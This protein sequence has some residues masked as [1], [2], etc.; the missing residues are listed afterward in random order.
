MEYIIY[1]DDGFVKSTLLEK[2]LN[3]QNLELLQEWLGGSRRLDLL[4]CRWTS[5]YSSYSVASFKS[6]DQSSEA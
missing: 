4:C 1:S 2:V 3:E 5:N 6:R